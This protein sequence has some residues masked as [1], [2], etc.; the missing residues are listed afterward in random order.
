MVMLEDRI[1]KSVIDAWSLDQAHPLHERMHVPVPPFH[2][3]KTVIETAFLASLEREEDRPIHFALVMADPEIGKRLSHVKRP[4]EYLLHLQGALPFTVDSIAKL[5]P[6]LDPGS[7]AMAV[8]PAETDGE[9]VIWGVFRFS[10][11]SSAFNE[12][13]PWVYGDL[14]YRPDLFTVYSANAG[15]VVISR[16]NSQIGRI[17]N[18]EFMPATPSPFTMKSLGRY[19]VMCIQDQE[20][21]ETYGDAF[22]RLYRET[23]ELLLSEAGQRGH[24]S[25]F[26]LVLPGS[27]AGDYYIPRFG[28]VETVGLAHYMG[29]LLRD[30]LDVPTSIAMRK[31]FADRVRFLAQLG[32][33]DGAVILDSQFSL[34]S[35]GAM[36]AA[37]PWQGRIITGPDGF[38]EGGGEPLDPARLGMR[39]NSALA[40]AGAVDG[41]IA[42]VISQD[43]PVRVF[44]KGGEDTLLYWPDCCG[45]SISP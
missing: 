41:S 26:A 15:S 44:V 6:A 40:F 18:G 5:A 33:V 20:L 16:H 34:E 31:T 38:G 14:A 3:V 36:L 39:H 10:P 24:G 4:S 43:G 28:F 12:I 8:G 25:I 11:T 42:F 13:P 27:K 45:A 30:D 19:L 9:L 23:I 21:Y 22:W 37:P 17:L 7:S 35:Y 32:T 2:Q 1:I 29:E